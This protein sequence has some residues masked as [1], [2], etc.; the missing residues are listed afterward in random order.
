MKIVDAQ[1]CLAVHGV[2]GDRIAGV[3]HDYKMMV[4]IDVGV[5]SHLG[6]SMEKAMH[7][8]DVADG[9][10]GSEIDDHV[11]PEMQPKHESV[12]AGAADLLIIAGAA[13]DPVVAA[14]ATK[15]VGET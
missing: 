9:W 11:L 2:K 4:D 1:G 14:K 7:L 5:V 13:V 6:E 10:T 12:L 15:N 8:D 3:H